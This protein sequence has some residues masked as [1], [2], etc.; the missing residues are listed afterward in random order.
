MGDTVQVNLRLP[1]GLVGDLEYI[2]EN[3]KIKKSDWLKVKIAELVGNELRNEKFRI[4]Q[5]AEDKFI[6]GVINEKEYEQRKGIKPS[7]ELKQMRD[8]EKKKLKGGKK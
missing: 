8:N 5:N 4:Y 1:K 3:L 7:K 2:A 6:R